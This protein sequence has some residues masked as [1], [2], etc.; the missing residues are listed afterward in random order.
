MLY[1]VSGTMP[2]L[3]YSDDQFIL[4]DKPSG[5]LSAPGKGPELRA[6]LAVRVQGEY[7]DALTGRSHQLRVPLRHIGHPVLGD[8]LYAHEPALAMADRLQL[9]ASRISFAH[10]ATGERLSFTSA[11]PF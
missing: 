6:S 1:H 3:L 11:C 8:K 10:P 9:H 7:S 4:L 2:P 5:L